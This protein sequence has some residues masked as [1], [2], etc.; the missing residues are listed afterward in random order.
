MGRRIV[1]ACPQ[2]PAECIGKNVPFMPM[3]VNRK[4]SLAT[5][6]FIRRP[7][8]LGTRTEWR[9]HAKQRGSEQ[10]VVEVSHN[11]IRVVEIDVDW[12]SSHE[13]SAQ[14]TNHEQCHECCA[15]K[16][17]RVKTQIPVPHCTDPV[18]CLNRRG[19]GDHH[20]G[21]HERHTESGIHTAGKH[22]V[23]PD[24]EAQARRWPP[25]NRPSACNRKSASG[26]CRP[27]C[28]K[29]YPLPATA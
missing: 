27:A 28:R 8:I 7:N 9:E 22:V 26:T 18:K 16:E 5:L 13:D 2:S 20:C 29:P 23:S 19:Q 25:W 24:D 12:Y 15:V 3:K 10:N 21:R 1:E 4:C 11:E 6:S 14:A 17:Y